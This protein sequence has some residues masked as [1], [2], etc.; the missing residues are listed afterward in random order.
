MNSHLSG[1]W[2][3]AFIKGNSIQSIDM[4]FFEEDNNL[5]SLQEIEDW[6]PVFGEF[7][8]PVKI[9]S[10]ENIVFNTGLGKVKVKLDSNYYELSGQIENTNPTIYVH[11]KKSIPPPSPAYTVEEINIPSGDITLAGHL[12]KPL[13]MSKNAII[14]VTGRGCYPVSTKYNLYA[15]I[16]RKYGIT[17]L[18]YRK[19]GTGAS[20]G[21][22]ISATIE[23]LAQ[24]VVSV[25]NYLLEDGEYE[26]IGVIGSSAGGWV[27]AKTLEYTPLDFLIGIVGPSTSVYD[28]QMQSMA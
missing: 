8:I 15:K 18:A 22:C 9:D 1:Y 12:H 6:Y 20:T 5:M 25:K 4:T 14:L 13:S 2:K 7:E 11:L 21:D 17:V 26:N 23:D 19:R 3:G 10:T 27:M 24:D 28:Q 16:L